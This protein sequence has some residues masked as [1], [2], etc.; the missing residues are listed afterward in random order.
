MAYDAPPERDPRGLLAPPPSGGFW[1][2]PQA[3]EPIEFP[4]GETPIPQPIIPPPAQG[5]QGAA[6]PPAAAPPPLPPPDLVGDIPPPPLPPGDGG[7]GGGAGLPPVG[8]PPSMGGPGAPGE[9][10]GLL[11]PQEAAALL[12]RMAASRGVR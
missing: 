11:P 8:G 9:G 4:A 2:A 1:G 3:E 10:S 7:L 5:G 12:A 6:P